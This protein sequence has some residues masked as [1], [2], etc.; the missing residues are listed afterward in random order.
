MNTGYVTSA[1]T[2]TSGNM[3][4]STSTTYGRGWAKFPLTSIPSGSV[5]TGVTIKFY[6]YGGTTS[7]TSNTI[8][9]FTGDPVTMT[10]STLYSTIG[11]GTVYETSTWT[12]GTTTTPSLN[13][14]V[15]AAA[16]ITYVQ[17]QLATGYVNFGFVGGSTSLQ[18]IYGYNNT[19]YSVRLEISYNPPAPTATITTTGNTTFCQGNSVTLNANTGT[20]LSYQWK[21]NGSNISGTNS[22]YTA[23]SS[24]SYTVQVTNSSGCASISNPTIVTSNS[25]PVATLSNTGSL[26]FCQ[27]GSVTLNTNLGSGLTY[28]WKKNGVIISGITT[29][30]YIATTTGSYTVVI[31]NSNG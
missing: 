14:K 20:G 1:G 19:T 23:S 6:T 25:L 15:L 29:S 31:T 3:L 28:Q 27:G 24:G 16:G 2:K 30:S 11:T 4:V 10:G 22:S 7:A 5:I 21:N 18:S 13:T 12:I 8:R 9:G 17:N 26:T